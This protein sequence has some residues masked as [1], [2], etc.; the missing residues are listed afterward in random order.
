MKGSTAF[1]GLF[2]TREGYDRYAPFF[3]GS[4]FRTP[5]PVLDQV[6][7][8]VGARPVDRALDVCCGTGAGVVMLRPLVR[9][10]VVGLDYSEGMLEVAR[11]NAAAAPGTAPVRLVH[12]DALG[13]TFDGVF[14]VVT[15]FGAFGHF[16]DWQQPA[17]L[18]R[19]HRALA[20]GGRFVFVTTTQPTV[21]DQRWWIYRGFHAAMA[22]RNAVV[23][24]EFVMIYLNFTVPEVL[25]LLDR[26]GFDTV[27]Y[28]CDWD[29]RP[30]K[31]AVA[32]KR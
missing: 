4:P 11:R 7:R 1:Y 5:E 31:I 28:D 16:Q 2:G 20:P 24:P 8:F 32:T 17:L 22:V 10:E 19:V 6:A 21:F 14:D 29:R 26:V 15:S 9:E 25:P 23:K 18:R 13:M 12:G 30:Y 27:L 3:D